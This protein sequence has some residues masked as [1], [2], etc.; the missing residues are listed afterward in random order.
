MTLEE[1]N[2]TKKLIDDGNL[3]ADQQL[4]EK[5]LKRSIELRNQ[6]FI[7]YFINKG[8]NPDNITINKMPV[9][10]ALLTEMEE[11]SIFSSEE[12]KERSTDVFVSLVESGANP[13]YGSPLKHMFN[14][15][16]Y[17]KNISVCEATD[18]LLKFGA[19]K[20]DIVLQE[21]ASKSNYCVGEE[22][23]NKD[24]FL[25]LLEVLRQHKVDVS[26]LPQY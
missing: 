5:F 10:K 25:K 24:V 22:R 2:S 26:N 14:L 11:S 19:E 16:L 21:I 12:K 17:N 7:E 8:A 23:F 6:D 1:L 13:N 9:L 18:A 20:K 4:L 3:K 15:D